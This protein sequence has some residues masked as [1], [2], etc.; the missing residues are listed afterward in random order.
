MNVLKATVLDFLDTLAG[1]R[2][3]LVPPR[4]LMFDG[5]PTPEEFRSNGREFLRHY[6]ELCGLRPDERILDVGSG[7]GRKSVPLLDYLSDAGAY[8]GFDIVERGVEWCRQAISAR[9]PNFR[10]RRVD[11]HNR[12]Y[13]PGGRISPL[14]FVFPYDDASF[15][16]VTAGSVFTHMLPP[17]V[18][19]YLGQIA[20]VL[21]PG[22]RCLIT[23]FL[24]NEES[25]RMMALPASTYAFPTRGEG[26]RCQE[27]AMPEAAVC[28]V[29]SAAKAAYD[30]HGLRIVEPIHYGAWCGRPAGRT[31]QDMVVA[32]RPP[33]SS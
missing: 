23:W 12:L 32:R 6:I 2:D 16:L 17:E 29:E 1:R 33:P 28:H 18:E 20:R 30:R 22:G 31:F 13:N 27:A 9:R 7:V 26:Y 10:F 19:R 24:S 4:R 15:D 11:V 5:P 14:E 8:D 21:K 25:D 3:P